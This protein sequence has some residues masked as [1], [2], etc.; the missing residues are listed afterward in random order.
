MTTFRQFLEVKNPPWEGLEYYEKKA[1]EL[2]SIEESLTGFQDNWK[3]A[4]KLVKDFYGSNNPWYEIGFYDVPYWIRNL[5]IGD[6]KASAWSSSATYSIRMQGIIDYLPK[7]KNDY[8]EQSKQL[9]HLIYSIEGT[10][11]EFYGKNK[12]F[13]KHYRECRR[14]LPDVL[15]TFEEQ[16]QYFKGG[17]NEDEDY[18]TYEVGKD[19]VIKT[20]K[21]LEGFVKYAAIVYDIKEKTEAWLDRRN[22][23]YQRQFNKKD[24][25]GNLLMPKHKPQEVLYHATVA[26]S[27]IQ[28][29]GLK[30]RKETGRVGLGGGQS[31]FISF[32]S[33]FQ[34]A[35]EIAVAIKEMVLISRG[36]IKYEDIL[37]W[38]EKG[39][40]DMEHLAY[41]TKMNAHSADGP[42]DKTIGLYRNYLHMAGQ[43]GTR[44]NPVFWGSESSYYK[45]IDPNDV[46]VISAIIDMS[47]VDDFYG[48]EE[49]FRVP[50]NAMIRLLRATKV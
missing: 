24:S 25:D 14:R 9:E 15:Q 3:I 27:A 13:F 8:H 11:Q 2:R 29:E 16:K 1:K 42:E 30:S 17:K 37:G 19:S 21:D 43:K 7:L 46:G 4:E 49:E 40:I 47:K 44:Y 39:G 34:L 12:D 36:Q 50:P 48:G 26:I 35:K 22:I 33:S 5:A 23:A 38:A 45:N 6:L 32:T 18:P 10:R 28:K 41:I 20:V 31:E